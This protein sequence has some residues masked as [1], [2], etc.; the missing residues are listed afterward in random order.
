MPTLPAG[1]KAMAQGCSRPVMRVSTLNAAVF[2]ACRCMGRSSSIANT[3]MPI[4][5]VGWFEFFVGFRFTLS[6]LQ[7]YP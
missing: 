3:S 1:K 4:S 7:N 5:H 6:N 2:C